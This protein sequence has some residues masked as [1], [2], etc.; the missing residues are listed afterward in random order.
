M[1]NTDGRTGGNNIGFGQVDD[2]Q[3]ITPADRENCIGRL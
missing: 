3:L 2:Q 1:M